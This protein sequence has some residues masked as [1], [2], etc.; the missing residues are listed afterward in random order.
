M[1]SPTPAERLI[2]A[3]AALYLARDVERETLR[4]R[5]E[6]PDRA[7]VVRFEQELVNLRKLAERLSV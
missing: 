1:Y 3:D 2:L 4:M 5:A 6:D 7:I